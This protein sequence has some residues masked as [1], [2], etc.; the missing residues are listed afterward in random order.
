MPHITIYNPSTGVI[1]QSIE[2]NIPLPDYPF[3]EGEVAVEGESTPDTHYVDISL[4]PPEVKGRWEFAASPDKSVILEDGIEEVSIGPFGPGVEI[5]VDDVLAQ[6]IVDGDP[7]FTMTANEEGTYVVRASLWP[8]FD[9]EWNVEAV[10]TK[11][12]G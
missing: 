6:T 1:S 11:D 10:V 12:L 8:Y 9:K 5:Y 4:D 7:F 3:E 2:S